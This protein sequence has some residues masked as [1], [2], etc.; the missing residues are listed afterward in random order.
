M[1]IS[2]VTVWSWDSHHGETSMA[3]NAGVTNHSHVW[4]AILQLKYFS[5]M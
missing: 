2:L 3:K 5:F 1:S 4:L